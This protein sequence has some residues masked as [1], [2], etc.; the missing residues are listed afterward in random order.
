M[1]LMDDE[2][3]QE[4]RQGY[5]ADRLQLATNANLYRQG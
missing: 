3:P 4:E 2:V 5:P 1:E